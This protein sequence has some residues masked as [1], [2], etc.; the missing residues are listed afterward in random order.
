MKLKKYACRCMAVVCAVVAVACMDDTYRLDELNTEISVFEEKTVLPLGTFEQK[1]LGDLMQDVEL[2][3]IV[4][5]NEDGSYEVKYKIDTTISAG[6]FSLQSPFEIPKAES[7]LKLDVPALSLKDLAFDFTIE[8][9]GIPALDIINDAIDQMPGDNLITGNEITILDTYFQYGFPTKIHVESGDEPVEIAIDPVKFDL[10][11]QISEVCTVILAKEEENDHGAPVALNIDLNGLK[12][13]NAGGKMIFTLTPKGNIDLELYNNVGAEIKKSAEGTYVITQ[14][15]EGNNEGNNE[16]NEGVIPFVFYISKINIIPQDVAPASAGE[17]E[18]DLSMTC[19]FSFD[20]NLK[21]GNLVLTDAAGNAA[22]PSFDMSADIALEDALVKFNTEVDLFDFNFDD[23]GFDFEIDGLPKQLV[24]INRINLKDTQLTLFASG[25]E[26]LAENDENAEAVSIDMTLPECLVL[27]KVDGMTYDYDAETH[28]LSMSI[29]DMCNEKGLVLDFEAIDFGDGLA[30]DNGKIAIKFA[31]KVRV[32]FDN[33]EPIS[34]MDFFPEKSTIDVV[35]GLKEANIGLE[36]VEAQLAFAETFESEFS[37]GLSEVRENLGGL[38]IGG[39]GLSPVIMLS[40]SN[41]LT[42]AA[43]VSASLV[44]M[45]DGQVQE[46]AIDFNVV[47]GAATYDKLTGETTPGVTTIVLA[48]PNRE[49]DFP[50]LE[51]IGCD[52]DELISTLPTDFVFNASFSLPDEAITLHMID[53]LAMDVSVDLSLPIAFDDKLSI[54]YEDTISIVDEAGKSPIAEVLSSTEGI[55]VGDVALIAEIETNLP[56]E[57][58]ASTTLLDKDG[59]QLPT[60]VGFDDNNNKI[61][62]S[63]NGKDAVKSTLRLVFDLAAEDGSLDELLDI[64]SV[65]L[66]ATAKGV[67]DSA[68]ALT[69]DQY[70]AATLKLEIDGGIT[71]DLDKFNNQK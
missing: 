42:I 68:V 63:E 37:T 58:V 39:A 1:R 53:E 5:R 12:G 54:K 16:E 31:P 71:V 62:G 3:E 25:L 15:I 34:V 59:N 45:V 19:D 66:K 69:D 38:E 36:S 51:F 29:A 6:E 55:K 67:A 70:I 24:S 48:K 13:I 22:E 7:Q 10:P 27:N 11:E 32:H 2:P 21:A 46:G 61:Q 64:H 57:L 9:I 40:L 30:P 44:P 52:I 18:L 4:D 43:N 14:D 50:G 65:M 23:S 28:M 56:L 20:L 26:W 35:I 8:K 33:G 47:I 60:K 17:M 41:P 49:G